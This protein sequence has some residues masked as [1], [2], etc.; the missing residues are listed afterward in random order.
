[1]AITN[2]DNHVSQQKDILTYKSG[3]VA[4]GATV[5]VHTFVYPCTLQGIRASAF[6]VSN[7]MQAAFIKNYFVPGAGLT[8]IAIGISNLVLQN[9][10]V[11]GSQNFSGLAATGST[12]LN[13]NA[14]DYLTIN[15]SVANGNVLDMALTMV[16]KKTQD[17]VNY[18]NMAV[19]V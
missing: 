15:T 13:F 11:S 10:S 18:N 4:T 16:V 7:A 5:F 1:M 14:G 6:G 3:A 8:S 9:A 12:L 2:A 19:G 17:I